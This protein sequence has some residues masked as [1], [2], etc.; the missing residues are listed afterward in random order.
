MYSLL[1]S[2]DSKKKKK[3]LIKS[4]ETI[5]FSSNVDVTS[6]K[7]SNNNLFLAIKIDHRS[8]NPGV[9][10][11]FTRVSRNDKLSLRASFPSFAFPSDLEETIL[12]MCVYTYTAC[13]NLPT[14]GRYYFHAIWIRVHDEIQSLVIPF[15]RSSQL[16]ITR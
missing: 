16:L 3:K 13:V 15:H 4:R 1:T 11:R 6:C 10:R 7:I 5:A 12:Y 2:L 9:A 8:L 14:E